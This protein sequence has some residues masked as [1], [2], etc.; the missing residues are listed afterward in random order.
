MRNRSIIVTDADM[1]SLSRLVRS[2]KH[3]KQLIVSPMCPSAFDA[4]KQFPAY[5]NARSAA[6]K[7]PA[8]APSRQS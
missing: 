6:R 8:L 1:D 4:I 3:K 7:V 2:L 5:L